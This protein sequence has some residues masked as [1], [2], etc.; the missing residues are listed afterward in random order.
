MLCMTIY[1]MDKLIQEH[2]DMSWS[3][4]EV[5]EPLCFLTLSSANAPSPAG[6]MLRERKDNI[7]SWEQGFERWW[8]NG[9]VSRA[10]SCSLGK[11]AVKKR[12]GLFFQNLEIKRTRSPLKGCPELLEENWVWGT[13]VLNG[14]VTSQWPLGCLRDVGLPLSSCRSYLVGKLCSV[15]SRSLCFIL[16][17]WLLLWAGRASFQIALD[18]AVVQHWF[19]EE[20][21]WKRIFGRGCER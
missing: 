2:W 19:L 16:N 9:S 8:T 18:A 21:F 6:W 17:H 1:S 12:R 14:A 15:F 10:W 11:E 20:D 3:G 4:Y 7:C 5:T 13:W